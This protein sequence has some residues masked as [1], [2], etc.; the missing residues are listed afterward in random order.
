MAQ[1]WVQIGRYAPP[2]SDAAWNAVA[3]YDAVVVVAADYDAGWA[4]AVEKA[5]SC[6]VAT[7]GSQ[8]QKQN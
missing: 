2:R 1:Y 3:D 4:A 6:Q 5:K 7:V 8:R